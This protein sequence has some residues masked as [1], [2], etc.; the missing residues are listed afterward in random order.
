ME[1]I[2]KREK[3]V[4]DLQDDEDLQLITDSQD[5]ECI[6]EHLGNPEWFDYG[7]LF[8][9]NIDGELAEIYGCES[10]IPYLHY[11]VDTIEMVYDEN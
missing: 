2:C 1:I 10:N 8:V 7:C 11:F 6:K 3:C 5:I 4:R 9:K